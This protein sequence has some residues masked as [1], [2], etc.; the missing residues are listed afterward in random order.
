MRIVKVYEVYSGN[1]CVAFLTH[2]EA[3]QQELFDEVDSITI[4]EVYF[5]EFEF[6]SLTLNRYCWM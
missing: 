5:T 3:L 1:Q 4:S 6:E 2:Q